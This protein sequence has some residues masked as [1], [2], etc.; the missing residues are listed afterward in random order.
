VFTPHRIEIH[1]KAR[2]GYSS[3]NMHGYILELTN[4][5]LAGGLGGT[6]YYGTEGD[7]EYSFE[8]INLNSPDIC[9]REVT[10]KRLVDK[11]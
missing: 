6:I 11:L 1:T 2:Y 3:I 7:R 10:I 8:A 9:R 5:F 4:P